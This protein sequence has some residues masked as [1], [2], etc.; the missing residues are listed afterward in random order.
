MIWTAAKPSATVQAVM[1]D[2]SYFTKIRPW[3]VFFFFWFPER[4]GGRE[5]GKPGWLKEA[6][7]L[8]PGEG[9]PWR[10]FVQPIMLE[11][12]T[13]LRKALDQSSRVF[14]Y[15]E[16]LIKPCTQSSWSAKFYAGWQSLSYFL[17]SLNFVHIF[18]HRALCDDHHLHCTCLNDNVL[19]LHCR[20]FQHRSSADHSHQA[21][22]RELIG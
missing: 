18:S 19:S 7:Q 15:F 21:V 9:C 17:L 16:H 5:V 4:K 22:W 11:V 8:T 3:E 10:R 20:C 13:C 2:E 6:S 1:D 12:K 14:R